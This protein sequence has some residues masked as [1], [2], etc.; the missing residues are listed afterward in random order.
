[1]HIDVVPAIGDIV[2]VSLLLLI[3]GAAAPA[4]AGVPAHATVPSIPGVPAV[5]GVPADAVSLF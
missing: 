5:T 4:I 3:F 2:A 1:L